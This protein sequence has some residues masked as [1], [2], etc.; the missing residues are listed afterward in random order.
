MADLDVISSLHW[1]SGI[2]PILVFDGSILT[3]SNTW[4]LFPHIKRHNYA[5]METKQAYMFNLWSHDISMPKHQLKQKTADVH[6]ISSLKRNLVMKPITLVFVHNILTRSSTWLH[7]LFTTF[8]HAPTHG[9]MACS[10]HSHMHTFNILNKFKKDE[11]K[12][13]KPL[14]LNPPCALFGSDAYMGKK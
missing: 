10:Q 11:E 1:N 2:K 8:S 5:L 4:S 6:A 14:Q 12:K 3:R 13:I 9:C 7:G